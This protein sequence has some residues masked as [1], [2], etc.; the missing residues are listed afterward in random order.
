MSEFN[1]IAFSQLPSSK[2]NSAKDIVEHLVS[3]PGVFENLAPCFVNGGVCGHK[4]M[5]LKVAVDVVRAADN[6]STL[7]PYKLTDYQLGNLI[8]NVIRS[9][10]VLDKNWRI[11]G[12]NPKVAAMLPSSAY[13]SDANQ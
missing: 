12:Y 11:T 4:V 3:M 13:D 8:K 7:A 6:T 2:K 9:R 10:Y 5:D 1:M